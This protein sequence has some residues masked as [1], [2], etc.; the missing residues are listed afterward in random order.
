MIRFT[1]ILFFFG[2][3]YWDLALAYS[4][5]DGIVHQEWSIGDHTWKWQT[6]GGEREGRAGGRGPPVVLT[7]VVTSVQR[8]YPV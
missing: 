5:R 6:E 1:R 8:I 4:R 7:P 2:T 3:S